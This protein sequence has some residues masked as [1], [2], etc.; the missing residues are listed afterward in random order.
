MTQR[1]KLELPLN[2]SV[3][4][5]L[6]YDEPVSGNSSYGNYNLYAVSVKGIEYSFF[7]TA[8]VHEQIKSLKKG[9]RATIT[10]LASQRGNKLV[11]T[12]E[13]KL[14]DAKVTVPVSQTSNDLPLETE[15]HD[16]FFEIMLNCYKDALEISKELNGMADSEKI[17]IT[18]FIA[19]SKQNNY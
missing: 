2:Q 9:S 8:E 12:Y 6:L 7:P 14:V 1:T 15:S 4:I 17:A 3:D 18:L 16:H 5:E 19:R 10:K 13:V 11:T